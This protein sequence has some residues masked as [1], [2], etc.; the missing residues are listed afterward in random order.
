MVT[1]TPEPGSTV[2]FTVLVAH[3]ALVTHR[4][5]V[6]VPVLLIDAELE[7]TV[8]ENTRWIACECG[9]TDAIV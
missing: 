5:P 6:Q 8:T 7:V 9:D 3:D 1:L 4:S 2:C